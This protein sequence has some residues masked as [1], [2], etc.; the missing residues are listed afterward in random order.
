MLASCYTGKTHTAS[1]RT[2]RCG[3]FRVK[4]GRA[5]C[6]QV[7]FN[8]AL[9]WQPR[10]KASVMSAAASLLRFKLGSAA[11]TLAVAALGTALRTNCHLVWLDLSHTELDDRATMVIAD[12]TTVVSSGVVT[13]AYSSLFPFTGC[14][15]RS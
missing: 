13:H 6:W 4:R 5:L 12:A 8:H 2:M 9:A 15:T 10:V 7:C 11:L 1:F 3:E 14:R